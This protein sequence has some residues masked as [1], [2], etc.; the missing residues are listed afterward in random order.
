MTDLGVA[1]FEVE[2]G[3][4]KPWRVHR[5]LRDASSDLPPGSYTTLRTYRGNRVVRLGQHVRR[6]VDSLPVPATLEAD[7]VAEALAR[8]IEATGHP[9]S[10]LR[11]TFAPPRLYVTVER[12]TPPAE[13]CYREG[14]RCVTVVARRENPRAKDTRFLATAAEAYRALP[15]GIDEGLMLGDDG[16]ILE[17]LSSNFFALVNGVLRGE[18][19]RVLPGVTRAIVLELARDLLPVALRA[20]RKDEIGDVAECF[21][22]SVSRGVLPVVEIDG[23]A[24][25]DGRPGPGTRELI[26][27]FAAIVEREA[28]PL[29]AVGGVSP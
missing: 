29:P 26:G 10:R 1:S 23:R 20:V 22:T 9:E 28:V 12:F 7:A 25:G 13:A 2:P 3:S 21:L 14:V 24:I 17:G 18:D 27:R 5:T 15:A 8:A 16:A 4:F 19:E 6:L 11:L